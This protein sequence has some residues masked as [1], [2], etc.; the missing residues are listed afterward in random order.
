[1]QLVHF[2][3]NIRT[4]IIIEWLEHSSPLAHSA[5]TIS[6][7]DQHQVGMLQNIMKTSLN[8][9]LDAAAQA[10]L[11]TTLNSFLVLKVESTNLF[12]REN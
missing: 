9:E 12:S 11:L 3:I 1:M 10:S 5:R 8:A 7:I 2:S 4:H 6:N